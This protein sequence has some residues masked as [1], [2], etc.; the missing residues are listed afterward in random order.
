MPDIDMTQDVE[1]THCGDVAKM[2]VPLD[3]GF[4]WPEF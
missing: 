4:F 2:G 3:A 1:C